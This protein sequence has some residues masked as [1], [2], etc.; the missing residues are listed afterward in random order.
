MIRIVSSHFQARRHGIAVQLMVSA[1]LP[2]VLISRTHAAYGAGD[3][4]SALA[5]EE[6]TVTA[7]KVAEPLS[8]VPMSVAAYDSHTM[9]ELGAHS[10]DDIQSLTP[11]LDIAYPAGTGQGNSS[12]VT[13]R[14]IG[15]TSGAA[16]TAVYIDDVPIQVRRGT[17]GNSGDPL[18]KIFDLER[19]EVLRGPQGTLFGANAEGGAIRYITPQPSLSGEDGFVRGEL[20]STDHGAS[21]Y[22][23]GAAAGG[24][25][26]AGV[27]GGRA[28]F[29]Y[30]RDGGYIDR[31]DYQNLQRFADTNSDRSVVGRVAFLIKPID[32]LTVTPGMYYQETRYNDA[33]FFWQSYDTTLVNPGFPG[34]ALGQHRFVNGNALPQPAS[35]RWLL[36]S[37]KVETQLGETTLTSVTGYFNRHY[38]ITT[39][40]TNL[41]GMT[42][43][44]I[45]GEGLGWTEYPLTDPTAAV[46]KT[47]QSN[48]SQELRISNHDPASRLHYTAGLYFANQNQRD[49]TNIGA[50]F[51][52]LLELPPGEPFVQGDQTTGDR[53][54]AAFGQVDYALTRWV[55]VTAG[56]RVARQRVQFEQTLSGFL[57]VG[58]GTGSQYFSGAQSETATTPRV[59]VTFHP[60]EDST[61]YLSYAKGDRPG[62]IQPAPAVPPGDQCEASAAQL[63]VPPAGQSLSYR[64]DTTTDFE[65]GAKN[66]LFDG[67]FSS[68]VSLYRIDW[69]DVQQFLQIPNCAGVGYIANLGKARVNGVDLQLN[70]RPLS[71]L[72]VML[73]VGYT[74]A[75][76][77]RN[78]Q[79]GAGYTTV[80][81]GD[82]LLPPPSGITP[83]AGSVQVRYSLPGLPVPAYVL[84][85]ERVKSHNPGPYVNN[86]DPLQRVS[87]DPSTSLLNGRLGTS[88][89][90][91]E[92][93]LYC[94]NILNASPLLGRINNNFG[95]GDSLFYAATFRPRTVGLTFQKEF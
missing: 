67:R 15:S 16:T 46:Q 68:A 51:L 85:D 95:P 94:N 39:D 78:S 79:V 32:Q 64:Q 1:L 59:D 52:S 11:G 20:A 4:E 27:L 26:M 43:L 17:V 13:I 56:V 14:G 7:Q 91:A 8:K 60:D 77:V 24:P 2:A 33:N 63:G 92:I 10:I 22:E 19:V 29:D 9:E 86:P 28:S 40:Y 5:L 44:A 87:F 12:F 93:A 76:F 69:K 66:K 50:N 71:S 82:T 49:Y 36:P 55:T 58:P 31:V 53:Q 35:D 88:L 61:Y 83:W 23:Y 73:S 25:L 70:A 48:L 84:L 75:H 6:V 62:G 81:S 74:D 42:A 37:L 3:T 41:G 90:G 54:Y 89:A 30:R 38:R 21:S 34:S 45:L 80:Y 18:P 57:A 65:I 47:G 72:L